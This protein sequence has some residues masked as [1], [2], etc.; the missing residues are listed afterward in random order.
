MSRYQAQVRINNV[1]NYYF[2]IFL[3]KKKLF[4]KNL[5]AIQSKLN[6]AANLAVS[7]RQVKTENWRIDDNDMHSAFE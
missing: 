6:T 7:D 1:P 5:N 4:K 3:V 2:I